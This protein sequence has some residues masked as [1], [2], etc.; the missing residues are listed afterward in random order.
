[1]IKLMTKFITNRLT[2]DGNTHITQY[3]TKYR[4]PDNEICPDNIKGKIFPFKNNVQNEAG[5]LAHDIF[6]FL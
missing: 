4:Q 5:R 2:N 1:M 6:L 3:L